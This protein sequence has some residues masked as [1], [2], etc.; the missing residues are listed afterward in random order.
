MFNLQKLEGFIPNSNVLASGKISLRANIN[1]L[2][3]RDNR[4][5]LKTI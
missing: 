1:K 5:N 4:A 2:I 3:P